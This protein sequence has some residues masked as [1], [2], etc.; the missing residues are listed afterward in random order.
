MS[1]REERKRVANFKTKVL[2]LR[3]HIIFQNL[4]VSVHLPPL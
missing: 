3:S 4:K 2:D 1:R